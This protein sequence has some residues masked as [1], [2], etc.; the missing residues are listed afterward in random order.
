[1]QNLTGTLEQSSILGLL[2]MVLKLWCTGPTGVQG[3]AKG[4]LKHEGEFMDTNSQD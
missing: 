4:G 3:Q 2:H 1:M